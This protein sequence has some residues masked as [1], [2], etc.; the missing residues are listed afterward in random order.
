M[1]RIRCH[2]AVVL[3]GVILVCAGASGG[4]GSAGEYA[5]LTAEEGVPGPFEEVAMVYG[6]RETVGGVACVWWQLEVRKKRGVGV[7]A[8]LVLRALTSGD[9]LGESGEG[10]RF[11]RYIVRLPETGE[12][13]EYRDVH[14]G[15]ALLPAWRDFERHFV[16]RA[17]KG[18]LRE[19]GLPETA[20]YLG[21]TLTLRRVHAGAAW[22]QWDSVKRLDLD[23]EL[24]V[25]TGRN[26]RDTEGKRL[27]QKPE[28]RNYTYVPFTRE[29]Y[30]V[31]MA[32]GMNLFTVSAE[33]AQWVRGEAVFYLRAAG[34]G[35]PLKYPADLYRS[36]YVGS[37]MFMDEPA[38]LMVGD[39]NVHTALRYFSDAAN[40]LEQRVRSRYRSAGG[41]GAF[42]LEGELKKAGVSF[43]EMRLE[44]W[45][46]PAWETMY[47]TAHYQLAAGLAGIVHEG[48][49]RLE[50]F[51]AAIARWTDKPRQHTP[52]EMLRYHY[53]FLRGAAR[54]TGKQWGTSIYGQ[55]EE[56]YAGLAVTLAYD[57]GARY[58]WF[59]TSDHD[60]HVPWVEQLELSR[61]LKA[62][63][64][65]HARQSIYRPAP[66]VDRAIVI[67]YGW[68]LELGDLWWIRA[69][70]KELKGDYARGY[71]RL[72]REAH[73]EIQGAMD[74]G[75]GFDV[76]VDG[77]QTI[78]GYKRVTRVSA[79]GE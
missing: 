41:Y 45:D 12:T 29:E 74:R 26:S 44:Q 32:A 52:E 60:H 77:G 51:D 76:V 61:K 6:P 30:G 49:Y 17:G 79:D 64:A 15:R 67:P 48:R 75:E 53:A 16:P 54:A 8:V 28:R 3:C 1:L 35:T 34:G 40:L 65:G 23:R 13:L 69:V 58:V 22:E 5:L 70:D 50:E 20:T 14:T 10:I 39:K 55:A 68:F 31:M 11:E 21:H 72:M 2:V 56:K 27:P 36:N 62:H 7:P 18:S 24:L 66:V 46:Y 63:A 59:W 33:Q 37:V 4:E 73:R 43:G 25:G 9:P 42:H 71:V 19:G 38:I 47:P 57:M 78:Q